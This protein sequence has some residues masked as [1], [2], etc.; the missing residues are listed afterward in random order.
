MRC[1]LPI[2]ATN[3]GGIA[4]MIEDGLSGLLVPARN[5]TELCRAAA[6][7]LTGGK[8]FATTMG[9]RAA[10]RIA[11]NFRPENYRLALLEIYRATLKDTPE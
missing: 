11:G 8:D 1:G 9:Q 2:A 5:P 4:D 6:R 10:A 3:V 7:L